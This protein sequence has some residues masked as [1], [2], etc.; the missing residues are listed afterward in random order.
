MTTTQIT[1]PLERE[2]LEQEE[3]RK[4]PFSLLLES[5]KNHS[6]VLINLRNNRKLIGRVRAFDR[7]MN[8]VLESVQEIWTEN[9]PSEEDKSKSVPKIHDRFISK[10]FLRGDSVILI[11]KN[12]NT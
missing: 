3:F 9:V 10:M 6:Q 11:V 1:D 5:V 2:R 7:H 12:I 4:G 8:M